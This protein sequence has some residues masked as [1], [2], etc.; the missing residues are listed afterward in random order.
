MVDFIASCAHSGQTQATSDTKQYLRLLLLKRHCK[1][2]SH[3]KTTLLRSSHLLSREITVRSY[4]VYWEPKSDACLHSN[5]LT[6]QIQRISTTL[7]AC[8]DVNMCHEWPCRLLDGWKWEKHVKRIYVSLLVSPFRALLET[9]QLY[10]PVVTYIQRIYTASS[11]EYLLREYDLW[12]QL[13]ES[14]QPLTIMEHPHCLSIDSW[15]AV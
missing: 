11:T 5:W 14:T 3:N 6:Y 10:S 9:K 4:W 12:H 8:C 13:S 1:A 2:C 15:C 7:E